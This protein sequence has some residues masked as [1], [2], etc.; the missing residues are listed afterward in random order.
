MSWRGWAS[1]V[2]LLPLA[3]TS[4][5]LGSLFFLPVLVCGI[6]L[7][8][9]L[10]ARSKG[11]SHRLLALDLVA[12][13]GAGSVAVYHTSMGEPTGLNLALLLAPILVLGSIVFAW[14]LERDVSQRGTQP[15]HSLGDRGSLISWLLGL[16]WNRALAFIVLT[17]ATTL[18]VSIW[19]FGLSPRVATYAWLVSSFSFWPLLLLSLACVLPGRPGTIVTLLCLAMLEVA[20]IW[21]IAST[22]VVIYQDHPLLWEELLSRVRD[23]G[24]WDI[25]LEGL[26]SFQAALLTLSLFAGLPILAR[27]LG[28]LQG[29][30]SFFVL[31][32]ALAIVLV[33]GSLFVRQSTAVSP[34]L[35]ERYLENSSAPWSEVHDRAFQP[36]AIDWEE[37]ARART[38]LD[39]PI[40]EPG[41]ATPLDSLAGRYR[42]RSIVFLLLESQSATHIA[43]LGEGAFAHEP[44]TPHLTRLMKEG[45]LFTNYIAA[46]FDT[47]SALWTVLTGLQLPMGDPA[48]VQRAPEAARVG[49]MPDFNA[50]GYRS[51]WLCACSPR[52]D[53]WD[54]LM[55]GAGVRWWIDGSESRHL[56]RE[57][58]TSWGMPDEAL[59]SIALER[60]RRSLKAGQPTFIGALTVSNHEPYSFPDTVDGVSLPKNHAGGIRYADY[61]MN[62]LIE[63]LRSVPPDDQPI[64]FVTSD[65][66]YI[67]NLRQIEPWGILALEGL[68]IP[69][70]L[71]L[72]DGFLAGERYQGVFSHEDALDLLY[73]LVAPQPETG[74][75]KF[76]SHHRKVAFANSYQILAPRSYLV[77]PDR[78]SEIES[79]W[80]LRET[81]APPERKRIAEAWEQFR[82]ADGRLWPAEP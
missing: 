9:V 48:G 68:R 39:A 23:P 44:S 54:L 77:S 33:S 55:T 31:L 29:K 16:H 58:W 61:A 40:W 42:G 25:F 43:G 1:F 51:D 67:E 71:L 22:E 7:A 56:S 35:A 76:L 21:H 5:Q 82:K 3:L 28:R 80:G 20:V 79:Y 50:L 10:V 81:E 17:L 73:L 63:R 6:A 8:L 70:L 46:G 74:S 72:P 13:L 34:A 65:T 60:Y 2:A 78:W 27:G 66:S 11:W 18:V 49:R 32:R 75:G 59:Y 62:Q 36:R 38:H 57:Y 15:S 53:N 47:R 4:F 52:F 24:S 41:P 19:A 12:L 45:L 69:G 37:A 64:I 14:Y 26:F 30:T